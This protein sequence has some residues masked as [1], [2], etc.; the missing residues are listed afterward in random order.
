MTDH[1]PYVIITFTLTFKQSF[2]YY[3]SKEIKKQK[4]KSISSQTNYLILSFFIS[5]KRPFKKSLFLSK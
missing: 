2:Y 5:S 3:M 1:S 4:E